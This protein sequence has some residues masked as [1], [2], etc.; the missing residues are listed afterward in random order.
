MIELPP[1]LGRCDRTAFRHHRP[2]MRLLLFS[3]LASMLTPT[4]AAAQSSACSMATI[5]GDPVFEHAAPSHVRSPDAIPA[6]LPHDTTPWTEVARI[7]R[8][9]TVLVALEQAGNAAA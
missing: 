1:P 9:T 2:V 7:T 6:L 8:G 5:L 3:V 4:L